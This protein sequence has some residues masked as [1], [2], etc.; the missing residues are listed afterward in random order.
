MTEYILKTNELTKTYHGMDAL[1]NI[2][3]TLEPGKYMD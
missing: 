3:I 1:K 2:S